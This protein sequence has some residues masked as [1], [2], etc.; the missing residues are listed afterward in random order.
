MDIRRCYCWGPRGLCSKNKRLRFHLCP[1]L[2]SYSLW[3]LGILTP[4]QINHPLSPQMSK[5]TFAAQVC[6]PMYPHPWKQVGFQT[7]NWQVE[8]NI[9]TRQP[10][11][12]GSSSSVSTFVS[13]VGRCFPPKLF[14]PSLTS[15]N[16]PAPHLHA[17]RAPLCHEAVNDIK[18]R[19][20]CPRR[21][22]KQRLVWR[23]GRY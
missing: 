9:C 19:G 3:A 20:C 14:R 12:L 16:P 1:A 6:F 17:L 8:V 10:S 2:F 5:L 23:M 21:S 22:G 4:L 7:D 15:C 11:W 13:K 18:L